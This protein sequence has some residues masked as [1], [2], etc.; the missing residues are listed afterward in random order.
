MPA[1]LATCSERLDLDLAAAVKRVHARESVVDP[2][3]ARLSAT[4]EARTRLT[5]RELEV[6]QL[7]CDGLSNKG[8]CRQ[9]GAD[10]NTVAVHRAHIAECAR[11]PQDGRT[12]DV[13][14]PE[15]AS[16][17]RC[18]PARLPL[19]TSRPGRHRV[20]GNPL[21]AQGTPGFRLV[22]VTKSSG[23]TFTHNNGAF[24]GKFLPETLGFGLC[25]HRLRR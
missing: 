23:L 8:N 19:P 16:S 5:T 9:A 2:A 21:D 14:T 6:L 25:L 11:C 10:A 12:R 17:I 22:D 24:G 7:I 20:A 13:R 18:E 4:G 1:L 3:V 15:M